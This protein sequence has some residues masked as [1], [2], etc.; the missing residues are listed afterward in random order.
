MLMLPIL[1]RKLQ[2]ELS[3]DKIF[4]PFQSQMPSQRIASV[5]LQER[6]GLHKKEIIYYF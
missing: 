2:L 4:W 1:K 6:S 5:L 3:E